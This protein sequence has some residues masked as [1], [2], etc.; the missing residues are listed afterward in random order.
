[1]MVI[2]MYLERGAKDA[3]A[4]DLFNVEVVFAGQA[5]FG[6]TLLDQVEWNT[7]VQ[8]GAQK[9]VATDARKAIQVEDFI[10]H[11][12]SIASLTR[13]SIWRQMVAAI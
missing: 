12:L 2:Q 5:E 7:E 1:M 8:E 9:H 10:I 11:C 3:A 4:G 6:Q 13:W